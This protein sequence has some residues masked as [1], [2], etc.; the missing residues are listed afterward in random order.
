MLMEPGRPALI[1]SAIF[2][3]LFLTEVVVGRVVTLGGG[4]GT[5]VPESIQF[6]VFFAAIVS[7][8]VAVLQ[9]ERARDADRKSL[10]GE[11]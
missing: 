4:G 6:V 11:A 5:G 8:V 3:L 10:P 7:F 1:V 9:K 2:F